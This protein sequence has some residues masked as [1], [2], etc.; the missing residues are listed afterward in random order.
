MILVLL[1]LWKELLVADLKET[2]L[3][4]AFFCPSVMQLTSLQ[5]FFFFCF[6]FTDQSLKKVPGV[7]LWDGNCG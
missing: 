2:K 3:L 4:C 6:L 7:P 1:L 5:I